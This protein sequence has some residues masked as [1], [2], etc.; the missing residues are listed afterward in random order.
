MIVAT[1][2]PVAAYITE[3]ELPRTTNGRVFELLLPYQ[4]EGSE[5]ATVFRWRW[6]YT[7]TQRA[8][9]AGCGI[10]T[11]VRT[12]HALEKQ[13]FIRRV[14]RELRQRGETLYSV[15]GQNMP[16]RGKAMRQHSPLVGRA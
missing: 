4:V 15:D 9:D 16:I 1:S 11:G 12:R 6:M 10:T 14:L 3:C 8:I 13:A 2:R 5:K 7:N